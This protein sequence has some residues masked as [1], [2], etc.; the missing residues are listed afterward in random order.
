MQQIDYETPDGRPQRVDSVQRLGGME[1]KVE[2]VIT[3]EQQAGQ[4]APAKG[5]LQATV[6]SAGQT[7]NQSLPWPEGALLSEG[8]RLLTLKMGLAEGTKYTVKMYDV[9]TLSAMDLHVAVGK[10]EPLDLLGRVVEATRIESALETI[11]GELNQVTYVDQ[12]SNTLKMIAPIGGL[13][14]EVLSCSKDAA[15][16]KPEIFDAFATMVLQSPSDLGDLSAAASATYVLAAQNDAKLNIPALDCQSVAKTSGGKYV[17][18]VS[19]PADA[20]DFALPYQG[21]DQAAIKALEGSRYVQ[22]HEP[23]IQQL[24]AKARGD[25][26]TASQAAKRL[27]R[28][29]NQY[30]TKKDLSVGYA[31]ALEVVKSRQGDCTEHAVLLAALCQASGLP[32]RVCVGLTYVPEFAG[33]KNLFGPHAWVEVYMGKKWVGLDAALPGWNVGHLALA[34]GNGNPEDFFGMVNTMGNFKIEKA[35]AE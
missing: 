8:M 18:T 3:L 9:S 19:R 16:T 28:F 21:D 2:G 7:T 1:Q 23:V 29:V 20:G 17:V 32:A 26:K 6:T 14:V 24:A 13:K 31:S 5:K 34:S 27:E 15:F 25:A 11:G 12:E 22:S 10:T 4:N 35:Q 33:Q 30:I